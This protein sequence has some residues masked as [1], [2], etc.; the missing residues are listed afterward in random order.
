MVRHSWRAC[1]HV[2]IRALMMFRCG[3]NSRWLH[4]ILCSGP[5]Y[6]NTWLNFICWCKNLCNMGRRLNVCFICMSLIST[7]D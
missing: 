6:Y 3:R 2:H 7:G 1:T 4:Y 5:G